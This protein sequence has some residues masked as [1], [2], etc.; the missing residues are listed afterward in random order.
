MKRLS[1]II[2]LACPWGPRGG[3]MYKSADYLLQAQAADSSAAAFYRP[4][5]TRGGG[6]ALAS[7]AVL[8]A[9]LLKLASAALRG[10][11]AGV[12]VNMGER[13]SFFRKGILLTAARAMGVP[14]VLHL[15]ASQFDAFYRKLPRPVRAWARWVFARATR[16]VVLGP[17]ARRFVTEE[18]HV[19]A[20]RVE[21]VTNGAPGL[22]AATEFA[23]LSKDTSR[24]A[25]LRLL[26]LGN[27]MERKGVS[28]LFHALALPGFDWERLRVT[29]AGGGNL[30][31][32]Q[33]LAGRLGLSGRVEFLG[34][35]GQD[36]A[37]EL[38]A[39]A[40]VLVLPSHDEG[41]PLVIL[42][43]LAQGVAVV[44]TPV[45]E[46]PFLLRDG[47]HVCFTPAGD[48]PALAAT[49]QRVLADA[50]LRE[51]LRRNGQA[52]YQACFT[53]D[54]FYGRIKRIHH[55]AFGI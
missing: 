30:S 3:G 19:P 48:A 39:A 1:K 16:V 50:D 36:Q 20:N 28:D 31:F 34:W 25:R 26:F 17:W 38:L 4:L 46:I 47:E 15:H 45:G 37:A 24:D 7:A 9:A 55:Q 33:A 18:L 23:G 11:L 51:N 44:C 13:L 32:Y 10:E 54:E 49:L 53:L 21:A 41:L 42:E 29:L 6:S 35:V 52:L 12:H 5:D 2:F 43:A 22:S 8:A 14:V 27:L 40:D